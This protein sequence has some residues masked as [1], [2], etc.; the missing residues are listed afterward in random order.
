MA[1]E[2]E[3]ALSLMLPKLLGAVYQHG[4]LAERTRLSLKKL[5]R[6]TNKCQKLAHEFIEVMKPVAK[7]KAN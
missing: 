6:Q 5:D 4:I 2:I 7:E 3:D 1:E